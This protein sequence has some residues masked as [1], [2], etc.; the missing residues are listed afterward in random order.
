MLSNHDSSRSQHG[1]CVQVT[2]RGRGRASLTAPFMSSATPQVIH[3]TFA[4]LRVLCALAVQRHGESRDNAKTLGLPARAVRLTGGETSREKRLVIDGIGAEEL[5][6]RL[7]I[8]PDQRL[9]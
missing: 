6:A 7:G 8:P 5:R 4:A 3:L 2:C 9:R 1:P